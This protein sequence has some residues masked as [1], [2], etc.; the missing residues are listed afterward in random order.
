MKENIIRVALSLFLKRGYKYVSLVDV[1]AEVGITKGGIYHYF[2]SKEDL[3]DAAV[4]YLFDQMEAK[5]MEIFNRK[6]SLQQVLHS[7]LVERELSVYAQ[8]M[9]GMEQSDY[10]ENHASFILEVMNHFPKIQER[11]DGSH[12]MICQAIE[13]RLKAA[14]SKGEIRANTDVHVLAVM[15]LA[16]LNGQISLGEKLNN[17]DVRKQMTDSFLQLICS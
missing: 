8:N 12:V 11:I 13:K 1:A 17:L 7:I 16:M 5:Y 14:V 2:S 6:G 10:R 3:L 9:L 15:I 4:H